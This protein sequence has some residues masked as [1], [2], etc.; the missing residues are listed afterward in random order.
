MDLIYSTLI[1]KDS[2]MCI[3]YTARENLYNEIN[4]L[5]KQEISKRV[6]QFK[7]ILYKYL[8]FILIKIT[9]NAIRRRHVLGLYKSKKMVKIKRLNQIVLYTVKIHR[10]KVLH[11]CICIKSSTALLNNVHIHIPQYHC[12]ATLADNDLF[13]ACP[14]PIWMC[15]I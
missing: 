12:F 9:L 14:S 3:I 13:E 4:I 1:L 15:F 7:N 10:I 11:D 8:Q 5:Q 2:I 6:A